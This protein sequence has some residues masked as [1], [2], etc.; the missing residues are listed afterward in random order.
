MWQPLQILS[1]V[2]IFRYAPTSKAAA[3][4]TNIT[5]LNPLQA[6]TMKDKKQKQK[7]KLKK[8]KIQA[9]LAFIMPQFRFATAHL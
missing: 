7:E 2:S 6:Y 5:N 3:M 1:F 8:Q 4:R 9:Y